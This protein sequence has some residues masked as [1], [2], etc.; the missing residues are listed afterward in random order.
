MADDKALRKRLIR[1][2][3]EKPELRA[4]LLPLVKAAAD[5]DDYFTVNIPPAKE[6]GH[7][8][9]WHGSTTLTR[10]AFKSKAEADKWAK[11]KLKG[12]PYKVVKIKG[13]KGI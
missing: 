7:M 9:E 4:D 13:V 1:L 6:P 8:T 11:S 10:G 3:Y 2:A 5:Q 12:A